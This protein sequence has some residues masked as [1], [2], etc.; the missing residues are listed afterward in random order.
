MS[1]GVMAVAGGAAA[2][3]GA[4]SM[5]AANKNAKLAKGAADEA[6]IAQAAE[7]EKL[8]EVKKEFKDQKFE[9]PYSNMENVY[10][11]LTVN[12]QQVQFQAQQGAQQRANIMQSLKGAAGG[13]GVAG[14]A[15][16]MANQGQLQAQQISASIGAQEAA[17]QKLR[18]GEAGRIQGL[19]R[20]GDIMVKEAEANKLSTLLGMQQADTAG[21]SQALSTAKANQMQ[22]DMAKTQATADAIS[23]TTSALAGGYT[24]G[25][26]NTQ[27]LELAKLGLT[28]EQVKNR[29][30]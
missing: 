23:S 22:A 19:E 26:G 17:N 25:I 30:G 15:Q 20:E 1:F 3:G 13:S 21:A 29:L 5:H 28:D 18:A 12:Q 11:D 16:A 7:Q 6:R 9:N 27:E 8:D 10:E 2:I 4:V 14:L 24:T